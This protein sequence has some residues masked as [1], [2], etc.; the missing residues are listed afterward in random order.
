V[1]HSSE[2]AP[3][4]AR[5]ID[6]AVSDHRAVGATLTLPGDGEVCVPV[7]DRGVSERNP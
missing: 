3:E 6:S 1:L 5:T 7:F 2:F 4:A